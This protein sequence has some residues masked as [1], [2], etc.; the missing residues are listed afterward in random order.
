MSR[1]VRFIAIP[2]V[3]L[4]GSSIRGGTLQGRCQPILRP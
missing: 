1:N 3:D 4:I 2:P